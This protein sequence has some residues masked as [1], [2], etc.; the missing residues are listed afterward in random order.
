MPTRSKVFQISTALFLVAS[1]IFLY[2]FLFIPPFVPTEGN[3]IG[4][5][6]STWL[7]ASGCIK[8]K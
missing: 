4:D 6:F 8:G 1:L 7:R 3:G 5:L 2:C